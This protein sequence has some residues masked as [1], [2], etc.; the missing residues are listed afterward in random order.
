MSSQGVVKRGA[1]WGSQSSLSSL[2]K[3]HSRGVEI[4]CRLCLISAV[5]ICVR[6]QSIKIVMGSRL[7][8]GGEGR[9]NEEGAQK[10]HR[11]WH[12]TTRLGARCGALTRRRRTHRFTPRRSFVDLGL[13]DLFTFLKRHLT[14]TTCLSYLAFLRCNAPVHPISHLGLG[15]SK[16]VFVL[17]QSPPKL[18]PASL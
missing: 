8:F 7:E 12:V 1:H 9:K 3:S 16:R 6:A 5:A 4:G 15:A 17:L 10:D 2:E 13:R 18:F 11:V 14:N